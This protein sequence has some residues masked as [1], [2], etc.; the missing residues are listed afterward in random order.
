MCVRLPERVSV[1]LKSFW[2]I[3]NP[4]K[5]CSSATACHLN[6]DPLK[7]RLSQFREAFLGGRAAQKTPRGGDATYGDSVRNRGCG[8][9]MCIKKRKRPQ[10]MW[11]C[12]TT[13]RLRQGPEKI[14]ERERRSAAAEITSPAVLGE[15]C[16][17]TQA[18]GTMTWPLNLSQ[19]PIKRWIFWW[20]IYRHHICPAL[21]GGHLKTGCWSSPK[22]THLR[23]A[24][25]SRGDLEHVVVRALLL[26]G[27]RH[28]I[29]FW[30]QE[31][32]NL[33]NDLARCSRVCIDNNYD[34]G[35][36]DRLL[37]AWM[38]NRSGATQARLKGCCSR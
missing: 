4:W 18:A 29:N 38:R 21:F 15:Q 2:I 31:T 11:H 12:K 6:F 19:G 35:N 16:S 7:F 3:C 5:R 17:I 25:E 32:C 9:N 37:P 34:S 23:V 28:D 10:Q 24:V 14:G 33:S 8:P 22:K 30:Y 27:W 36:L 13:L 26:F 1:F 20:N